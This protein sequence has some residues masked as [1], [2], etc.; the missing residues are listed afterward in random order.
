MPKNKGFGQTVQAVKVKAKAHAR[1][2]VRAHYDAAQTT[3]DNIRYWSSAD[4]LS[5]DSALS[6]MVRRIVRNRARYEV[7]NNS[8]AA[9]VIETIAGD[10]IG[11][12]P[13]LQITG[14][15]V[16][17]AQ[18]V[19]R[20]FAEWA[21]EVSLFEK[22]NV[23]RRA[24]A[25]DGEAFAI[26]NTNRGLG[27]EIPLD[28]VLIE[29]DRVESPYFGPKDD[30]IDGVVVDVF[31]YPVE[32]QILKTHPGN[33][34]GFGGY[35]PGDYFTLPAERV[36][37][38]FKKYRPEQHR[39]IS[40][41]APALSLFAQLRRFTG[42]VTASAETAAD[43]A[44]LLKSDA[45]ASVTDDFESGSDVALPQ[46]LIDEVPIEKRTGT[47]LPAGWDATQMRAEQPCSTYAEFKRELLAE[48]GR[49]LCVPVNVIA[50]DSSKHNYA[51]GRLDHQVYHKA[52]R[53]EQKACERVVLRPILR[54]WL[55]EYNLQARMDG[56]PEVPERV[57]LSWYWD[58]FEH[59]DPQKTANSYKTLLECG[60]AS[61]GELLARQGVDLE[62]HI[63][64]LAY[65]K[66]LLDENGLSFPAG[67]GGTADTDDG[68]KKNTEDEE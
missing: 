49:C 9:G 13:R 21:E 53:L 51:S 29:A 30:D 54:A 1:R 45:P 19:E 26:L 17:L 63:A 31:G 3:P 44:V 65:E 38:W 6:P 39:G 34:L 7:A 24:K 40:E 41:I 42:A 18:E 16:P 27:T 47:V 66:K 46:P 60:L 36:I 64:Q 4:N 37:H 2:T 12:G 67:S 35:S 20:A 57:R 8:Y 52:I 23:M 56:R 10:C 58:G 55:T 33:T 68:E 62:E 61:M 14:W 28:L 11:T 50:G 15:E 48:I 5:A 32:Y 22:L 43:F 25:T 59:V